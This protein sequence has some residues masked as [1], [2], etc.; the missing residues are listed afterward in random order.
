MPLIETAVAKCDL[1]GAEEPVRR[2]SGQTPDLWLNIKY[3]SF[4]R[5][6]AECQL[7]IC[8]KHSIQVTHNGDV[9]TLVRGE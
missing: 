9:V 8:P 4:G 3:W 2:G 6:G 7:L 1:C 5:G